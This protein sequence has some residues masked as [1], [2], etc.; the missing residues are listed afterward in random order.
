MAQELYREETAAG[1]PVDGLF[2]RTQLLISELVVLHADAVG[3]HLEYALLSTDRHLAIVSAVHAGT[4]G[5]PFQSVQD[6]LL[7]V[8]SRNADP[9]LSYAVSASLMSYID[10]L[11]SQVLTIAGQN[12]VK[13]A[14]ECEGLL[15]ALSDRVKNTYL[16]RN[17]RLEQCVLTAKIGV[18]YMLLVQ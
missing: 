6:G 15:P 5:I 7:Q 4:R 1:M 8:F 9:L 13:F 10:T 11:Y 14:I 12:V 2:R 3:K 16:P 17:S 18:Y